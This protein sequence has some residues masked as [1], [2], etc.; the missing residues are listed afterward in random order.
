MKRWNEEINFF[1]FPTVWVK[2]NSQRQICLP[3]A[4][5]VNHGKRVFDELKIK[6]KSFSKGQFQAV[7]L[8]EVNKNINTK[9]APQCL[10]TKSFQPAHV[11]FGT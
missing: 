10:L 6:T 2:N 4:S 8:Q 3:V 9:F 5:T 1:D 7:I 11:L